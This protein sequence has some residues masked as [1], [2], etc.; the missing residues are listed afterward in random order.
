M[1][2]MKAVEHVSYKQR[3]R[4]LGPFSLEKRRLQGILSIYIYIPEGKM[5]RR[6]REALFSGIQ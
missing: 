1:K 2:M 6:Q 3:L 5:Q 4:Q